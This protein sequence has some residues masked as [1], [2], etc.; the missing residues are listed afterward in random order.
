MKATHYTEPKYPVDTIIRAADLIETLGES[1][2]E[3]G[4]RELSDQVGLSPSTTHRL[5]DTLV[6][7]GYVQKNPSTHQYKL[8]IGLFQIGVRVLSQYGMN[9]DVRLVLQ[10]LAESTGETSKLGVR[11]NGKMVY[12]GIV[13]SS[14]PL[15][16]TGHVGSWAPLHCTAMGKVMLSTLTKKE[17]EEIIC[18][19]LPL[20]AY[21][22]KSITD[23]QELL[24]HLD[25]VRELGYAIDDEE[26]LVGSRGL[27]TPV[28]N[29]QGQTV[30]AVSISGPSARLTSNT[31]LGFLSVV[32]KAGERLSEVTIL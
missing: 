7:V 18:G 9:P 13:E 11:F 12:L 6:S 20:K 29:P 14:N 23:K 31:L 22:P 25:Q 1:K 27:A 32:K 2:Q 15:R 30:A 3:L 28:L 26:F 24:N 17:Q 4:I 5:L 10:E 19:L 8:G 21:T 16:F